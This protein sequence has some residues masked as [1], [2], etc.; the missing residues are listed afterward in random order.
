[1]KYT[2]FCDVDDVLADFVGAAL[3]LI[4]RGKDRH[5]ITEWDMPKCLSMDASTFWLSQDL[6][7][8]FWLKLQP[9][10]G[11]SK[12]VENLRGLG[13]VYFC[14]RPSSHVN[15]ASHKLLWLEQHLGKG[16]RD[17]AILCQKK[18]LLAGPKRLLIDDCQAH[19]EAWRD[20]G[21]DAVTFPQRW[22]PYGEE[23]GKSVADAQRYAL[24]VALL[25]TLG[26]P[27]PL[28]PLE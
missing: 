9:Y 19:V 2:I 21:G 12:W 1:M 17:N 26:K 15:C 10:P 28:F 20:A 16:A 25:Y 24:A 7:E 18:H 4:G 27:V 23:W 5:L 11:I 6:E 14:T 8:E 22:N 3:E 13:D